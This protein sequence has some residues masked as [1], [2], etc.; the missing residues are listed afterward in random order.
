MIL[1]MVAT[2]SI[3]M[4]NAEKLWN[5]LRKFH[6]ESRQQPVGFFINVFVSLI[7]LIRQSQ[8]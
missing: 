1:S 6:A 3:H 5:S 4:L 8:Y 2:S 7:E